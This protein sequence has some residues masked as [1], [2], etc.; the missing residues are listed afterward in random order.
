MKSFFVASTLL[1][2]VSAGC[3]SDAGVVDDGPRDAAGPGDDRPAPPS[4]GDAATAASDAVREEAPL[5]PATEVPR[6]G[7]GPY[8]LVKLSARNLMAPSSQRELA[9]V[10]IT[11]ERCSG[12]EVLTNADGKADV[13]V[14]QGA[15]TWIRF[16][17]PGFV[18][19]LCGELRAG[20]AL[21]TQGLVASMLS[22]AIAPSFLTSYKPDKPLI[23]VQV[24]PG[25]SDGPA[26]CR[27]RDNVVITVKDHPEAVVLYRE[28]G[29]NAPY[30]KGAWTT[31]EGSV[32][33]SGLPA[34]LGSV[35]IVATKKGCTY[36]SAYGDANSPSL[37]PITKVP[38]QDGALTYHTFNPVR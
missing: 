36:V 6:C 29:S 16:E 14:S 26:A 32:I 31:T 1:A 21:A 34:S 17:A 3:A 8:Q 20:P 11:L 15:E 22:E 23:Y 9:G 30:L 7:P 24:Q 5:A 19:W 33:V 27:T 18:P 37:V 12:V 10:R 25:R 2:F 28:V 4:A 35:E 13:N 38:L